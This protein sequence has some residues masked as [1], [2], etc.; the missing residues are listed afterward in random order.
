[1]SKKQKRGT[2]CCV[3]VFILWCALVSGIHAQD[4]GFGF[5]E[6]AG[7]N[8]PKP[9]VSVKVGGEIAAEFTG[10]VHDFSSK[11]EAKAASL[12][13]MVSGALNF[14]ASGANVDA[15][16][17]LNLSAASIGGLAALT[18]NPA[19][20]PL[21]LDEVFLRV[22]F[23]PVNVEAGYRKLGWGKADSFGPLDI[24]NPLDYTDLTN[25]SDIQA[26]KIAR[27][28]VHITWNAGGFSKLEG[29]FIPNFTGHR[30]AREGPWAP[31]QYSTMTEVIE[32]EVLNRLSPMMALIPP[33]YAS[34]IQDMYTRSVAGFSPEFPGTSALEYFQTGLRF[35]TTVGPADIGA[36]YFYGS[37]FRPDVIFPVDTFV[38]D[39]I[40]KNLPLFTS[41]SPDLSNL[42]AGD[43][44]LLYKI[45]YNRYH[46]LGIDYA[47]VLF[48]LNV[49]AEC[50][51]HLTEDLRGD[52]GS[53]RN[54]FIGWSLGFDRDL[55]WG[56]N[57]N[58][59]CNETI[60]LFNG[61]VG[62]NPLLDCEADTNVTSTRITMQLSK[63]FLRDEL[64]T[65]AIVIWD[66]EDAGCYIIPSVMWTIKD[67]TAELSAG[68]FAGK[69]SGELGQYWEN[70]FVRLGLKYS[71]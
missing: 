63:K 3:I 60:R 8:A 12:G 41:P 11:E 43:T 34:A 44:A 40:K 35:T 61:K 71:F 51:I 38:E 5:D 42:Y 37:L 14:S 29:V 10:Y 66:I 17:G 22:Y 39:L 45:K 46:Q 24:I 9:A 70:S 25:I 27:P 31:A 49:R 4:F 6:D 56:I 47:Q 67:V 28:M 62:D 54:P 15:F 55:F 26:V 68:V 64:E 36:Q 13:D 48:G 50:A 16:I 65:R 69:E 57:A 58:V 21:I 20:T 33:Q 32:A 59:Q 7:E 30:F 52:D 19:A 23:G 2:N 53:V 1:M 18:E